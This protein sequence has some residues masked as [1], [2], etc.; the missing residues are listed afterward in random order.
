MVPL[1]QRISLSVLRCQHRKENKKEHKRRWQLYSSCRDQTLTWKHYNVHVSKWNDSTGGNKYPVT[2]GS[3]D[4]GMRVPSSFMRSLMLNLR[5]LSTVRRQRRPVGE[6]KKRYET[7]TRMQSAWRN[8]Q[9]VMILNLHGA[10][11][12]CLLQL[13][14]WCYCNPI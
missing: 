1:F 9:D 8:I 2:Y 12:H 4:L 10:V 13:Y 7:L 11:T 5:L 6:G 14:I 3:L